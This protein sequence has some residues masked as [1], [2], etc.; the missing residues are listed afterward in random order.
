VD[1]VLE[2]GKGSDAL[3][4]VSK[5]EAAR[6]IPFKPGSIRNIR[7]TLHNFDLPIRIGRLPAKIP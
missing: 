4:P 7:T 2:T 5:A 3:C 1:A 6:T